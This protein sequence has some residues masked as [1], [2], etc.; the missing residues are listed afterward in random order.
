MRQAF[1]IQNHDRSI[2][3]KKKRKRMGDKTHSILIA[4]FLIFTAEK[5]IK[6]FEL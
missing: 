4:K 2:K 5:I 6:W 3:K 1:D